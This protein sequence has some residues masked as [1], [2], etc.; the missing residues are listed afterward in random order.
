MSNTS[1][2]RTAAREQA[3]KV[4]KNHKGGL[5]L[6]NEEV[7][8]A[9]EGIAIFLRERLPRDVG[10]PLQKRLQALRFVL[11]PVEA[12][13]DRLVMMYCKRDRKK[14]PIREGTGFALEEKHLGDYERETKALWAER[15]LVHI[16]KIRRTDIPERVEGKMLVFP[17]VVWDFLAPILT[18]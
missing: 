14:E 15:Q 4:A 7:R 18:D 3:D 17:G 6:S 5:D 12:E 1:R 10:S 2:D 16:E 8:K 13:N 11:A 9:S